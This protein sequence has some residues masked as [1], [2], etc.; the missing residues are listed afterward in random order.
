MSAVVDDDVKLWNITQETLPKGWIGLV[1]NK[2]A[3]ARSLVCLACRFDVYAIDLGALSKVVMPHAEA[4]AAENPDLHDVD[5][6]TDELPKVPFI[7]RKVVSPLPY[8]GT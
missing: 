2:Y 5:L 4:S 8:T 6:S 3:R 1:A 7:D